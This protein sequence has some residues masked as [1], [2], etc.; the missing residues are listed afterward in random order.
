MKATL[1]I[2]AAVS[3][4][5][6]VGCANHEGVAPSQNSSL[7]AVSPS[8]TATSEGGSMQRS[9]DAWLKEEWTPLTT[10]ANGA[11][12]TSATAVSNVSEPSG[13]VTAQPED[14]TPLTLQK[15]ADKWKTYHENKEKMKEGKP[16]EA[17]HIEM[18]QS[19]PVVGK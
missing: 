18:M 6:L 16:K 12:A 7:N 13:T 1:M 5:L 8:T 19:L 10:P 11:N 9:L 17:S 2:T 4:L 15:Y 14:N 3:A